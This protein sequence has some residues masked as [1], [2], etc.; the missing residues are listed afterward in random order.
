[1][2]PPKTKAYWA[3]TAISILWGTTWFVSKLALAQ[4]PALQLSAMRQTT[5]GLIL[6]IWFA[7]RSNPWLPARELLFHALLGFLFFT[8]SNGLSTW[9]ITYIPSFMGALIGCLLP[10]MLVI[11]NYVLYGKRVSWMVVVS[12]LIGFAGI[13]IIITSFGKEFG[14]GPHFVSGISLTLISLLT[15]T[16]GTLL[17]SKKVMPSNPYVGVAW[18]MLFGGLMLFLSSWIFETDVPISQI[19]PQIWLYFMYLVLVGSVMCFL[20]YQY[21]IKHLPLSLVSVYVYINPMVAL[22]LGVWLLNEPFHWQIIPGAL[23]TFLGIYGVKR[24]QK[25]S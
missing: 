8:C 13:F 21:A 2:Y 15:W 19:S 24:F 10:F 25:S 12:L 7:F 11:G 1:M 9:G 5:A 3:L 20:S 17:L 14:A 16:S 4:V 22:G 18:Q 23:I 6:L